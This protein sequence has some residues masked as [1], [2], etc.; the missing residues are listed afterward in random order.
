MVTEGAEPFN[1][2]WAWRNWVAGAVLFGTTAAVVLWQNAHVAAL[3]D[4]SYILNT[5]TRIALGQLPYRDFPL[6]HAPLTFLTQAAIIRLTG[7]VFFHHVLYVSLVGGTGT[8][9]TWRIAFEILRRR[10]RAAWIIALVLAAPLVFLGIYCIVPNPEYD[11]D[12]AFWILVAIWLL[13]GTEQESHRGR[14]NNK[15]AKAGHTIRG[16]LAGVAVC[17]P[18]FFKQNMGL[19]FLAAVA[20]AVLLVLWF[21]WLRRVQNREEWHDVP[22]LFAVLAGICAALAVAVLALDWSAGIGNYVQ[23]TVRYAAQRRLPEFGL[24][25]DIYHDPTLLWTLPCVVGGLLLVGFGKRVSTHFTDKN[26]DVAK[27]GHPVSGKPRW[28]QIAAFALMAAPFV[29][30]LVSLLIYDDAD[31]RGDRL[32]ALWPL[33]VLLGAAVA[34]QKLARL[35]REPSL[36]LFLPL[37]LL[38]T[39]HGTWMSQQLWG[40]TYAIWALLV[41]LIAELI[42]LL[43]RFASGLPARWFAPGMAAVVSITLVVCGGFYTSSEERLSYAHLPDEPPAHS[44]FPELAGLAIPGPYL[45]EIDELLRYAK[46]NIPFDDG[47]VL[48]P[49]EE[50][51]YFATGRAQRF[52]VCFFDP[53][54]DPYT[55]GEIASLIRTHNIRWLIVKTDLQTIGDPTPDRAAI[56]QAVMGEFTLATHLRGYDVYGIKQG[57]GGS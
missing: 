21:K 13:Q 26:Q 44:A 27:A 48:I 34:A 7:R 45:P 35:P 28:T 23:W 53:T 10:V 52:P 37:I 51:F 55:P 32:L 36:R 4:V 2:R 29:F 31:E 8:V 41:L 3:F 11:C 54:I 40:S 50:P 49:G 16:F 15:A 20:G 42:A 39:I 19:L 25:A 14:R 18:L 5:A 57:S 47:M 30:A 12:C 43:E 1:S 38:A 22:A 17:V 56:M 46:I 6:P 9:F 24:M 33:V